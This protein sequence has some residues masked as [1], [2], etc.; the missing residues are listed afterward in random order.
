M[1]PLKLPYGISDFNDIRTEHFFYVDKTM[2][3][4]KLE[5]LNSKYLFFI[6]PRRFGKSLFLSMLEHYYDLNKKDDFERLFGDL[7]IGKHPTER[8][9]NYFILYLDFSGLD[10]SDSSLLKRSFQK[11]FRGT[12]IRFLDKYSDHL[13]NISELKNKIRQSEDIVSAW[14]ILFEAVAQSGTK[15]YLIIDEYD[16]FV[17]KIIAMG[18]GHFYKEIIHASGFVRNFYEVVKIGTKSVIDRIFI[19]GVSPIMLDDLTSGFNIAENM[20]MNPICGEMLGFTEEEVHEMVDQFEF[21]MDPEVIMDE[22]RSNYNGYLFYKGGKHKV[23]NPD[24]ILYFFNQWSMFGHFPEQLVDDNVKIDYDRLG[25]LVSNEQN[26]TQLEE[27]ILNE[28]VTTQIVSRFSF[29]RMYD[30]EYFVSLLFYMGLLTIQGPKE[31]LVELGIPNY[32]IK[33]VFWS[34]FG[35]IL[36]EKTGMEYR[37][38]EKL[39]FC[40]REMAYRGKIQPFVDFIGGLLSALSRRDLREFDE[41]YIKMVIL[42]YLNLTHMYQFISEREVGEGYTDILLKKGIGTPEV[43]YEWLLELKYLKQENRKQLDP[44]RKKASKQIQGYMKSRE[45]VGRPNLKAVAL[46]FIGK[47]EIVIDQLQ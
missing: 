20:T 10:T 5:R 14:E 46:I 25:S 42:S 31:G 4:E 29:D 33:T 41:K 9:N 28:R 16:H 32:V 39:S 21:N 15:I 26:R 35:R 27:I 18:D 38:V 34:Y 43:R 11:R 1:T 7:Y 23:Y 24:M 37:L 40:V 17:N 8:R 2:Y 22:L 30:K 47:D 44:I 36:Q 12:V 13:K 19:T 45:L 3:I 6:R